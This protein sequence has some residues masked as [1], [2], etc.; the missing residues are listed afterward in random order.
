M[1]HEIRQLEK[2]LNRILNIPKRQRTDI[3][4]HPIEVKDNIF[5]KPQ[6]SLDNNLI[7]EENSQ[8]QKRIKELSERVFELEAQ[9][10]DYKSQVHNLNVVNFQ[11]TTNEKVLREAVLQA[12]GAIRVVCR[13]K[14]TQGNCHIRFDD[15]NIFVEDKQYSLNHVFGS[16]SSQNEIFR[17][18]EPEI[19]SVLEGYSVCIFAYGQTGS[20]KTYTMCGEGLEEGLIFK[21]LDKIKDISNRFRNEGFTVKYIVKYIE[22]YN[23]NVRDLIS[24]KA[25]TI[26]HDTHSIKLKDCEEVSADDIDLISSI[27]KQYSL[28]RKTGETNC[29]VSSSRSHSIFILNVLIESKNEK[30]QGSLCLID[31]AGSE[32]L[33]E[34]KAENERL[35]ETQFINKSLS[36]LGNVMAALKRKDKHVPFRDS[37]L[38]HIMQ[39]YLSGRSRTSMIVNINPEC[40]EETICTL[41]FA[42]KVSECSLGGASKNINKFI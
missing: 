39:E 24:D 40:I 28:K 5:I 13:I 32:R 15:K 29:N 30:R 21:S 16:S 6:M 26:V 3:A 7:I 22:V 38:T 34:S 33:K 11:L 23:E 9:L 8:L 35:K 36:A 17:E 4:I 18:V 12:K 25:V 37:K 10:E 2:V 1:E 20:G 27:I 14:P 41:R 31:L 19:E 42:I